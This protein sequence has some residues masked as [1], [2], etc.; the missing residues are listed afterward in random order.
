[1]GW[2]EFMKKIGDMGLLNIKETPTSKEMTYRQYISTLTGL[3]TENLEVAL[4][5]HLH[6]DTYSSV[7]KKLEWL[8]L[9][10]EKYLSPHVATPLDV[11]ADR[12][13]E[14]LN[15]GPGERDMA[16]LHHEFISG[17]P[18]ERHR[19]TSTFIGYGEPHGDSAVARTVALPA[20]IGTAL[21]LQG[22][23]SLRGVRIPIYPEIYIPVLQ[24]LE[25]HGIIF[26]EQ[27]E[28]ITM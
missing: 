28:K 4:A 24:E 1:M 27:T 18:G 9:L 8:D 16:V 20:A 5:K 21:L 14:K 13:M 22:K 10:S 15:Y 26:K 3:P 11:L 19:V 7:M 2:C 25:S 17:S 23:I 12:M 6:I